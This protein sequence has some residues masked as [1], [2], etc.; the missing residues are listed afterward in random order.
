LFAR[1]QMKHN[2]SSMVT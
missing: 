1:F 2:D